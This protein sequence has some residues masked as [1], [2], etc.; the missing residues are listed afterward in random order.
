MHTPK[1]IKRL[2]TEGIRIVWQDGTDNTLSSKVLREHCPSAVS[3]AKRGDTS[4]DKP[5]SGKPSMLKVVE[6]SLDEEI[7]LDRIWGVGNYAIGI[8]WGDGHN[9]GIYTYD[10][11]KELSEKN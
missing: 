2:G 5:L 9:S 4:H 7:R 1:E 11:L 8:E 6:A 3:Q 10:Y